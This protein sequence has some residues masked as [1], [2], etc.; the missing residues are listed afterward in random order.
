MVTEFRYGRNMAAGIRNF[1][2][3]A[4]LVDYDSNMAPANFALVFVDNHDN[5]RDDEGRK[6]KTM[7]ALRAR[8]R[9]RRPFIVRN[10]QL[11]FSGNRHL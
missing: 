8:T 7:R 6:T 2:E 11:F 4:N 5:Q 10:V 1:S 3:L 9:R